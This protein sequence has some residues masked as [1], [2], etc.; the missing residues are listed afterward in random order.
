MECEM[1]RSHKELH[2][3]EILNVTRGIWPKNPSGEDEIISTGQYL[4]NV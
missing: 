4:L 3:I 2:L 1:F